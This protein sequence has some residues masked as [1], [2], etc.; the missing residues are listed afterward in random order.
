MCEIWDFALN[1]YPRPIFIDLI[2]VAVFLAWNTATFRISRFVDNCS[3]TTV[4]DEACIY[5]IIIFTSSYF[6]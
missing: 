3:L 1:D 4:T 2:N 6:A 5:Q